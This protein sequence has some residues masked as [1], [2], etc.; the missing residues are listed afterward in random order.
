MNKINNAAG[1]TRLG[2]WG[3]QAAAEYL[4]GLGWRVVA[5]N[6]RG[7]GG[8]LDLVALEPVEGAPPVGVVVEVKCRRGTGFGD[9]LEAITRQKNSRLRRLAGQWWQAYS[10]PL[11]GLRLDAVGIVKVPGIRPRI[12][13]VR[14]IQ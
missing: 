1:P 10:Q 8:E 3:E 9:P 13:H 2:A 12:T 5:R 11:S 4:S 14:G 7:D 6:W